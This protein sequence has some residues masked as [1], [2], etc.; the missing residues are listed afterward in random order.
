MAALFHATVVQELRDGVG[1]PIGVGVHW[2]VWKRLNPSQM[3]MAKK[4]IGIH[5][6]AVGRDVYAYGPG[7]SARWIICVSSWAA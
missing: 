1:Y 7:V 5:K 4:S 3:A 2:L 6:Q